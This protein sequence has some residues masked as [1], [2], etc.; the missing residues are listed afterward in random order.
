MRHEVHKHRVRVQAHLILEH[1]A[2]L[3]TESLL[4]VGDN[5]FVHGGLTAK[6]LDGDGTG[7][8]KT[9]GDGDAA[10]VSGAEAAMEDINA[11]VSAW[12]L[13]GNT[14][15][16]RIIWGE[17]SPVWL[18]TFSSPDSRDMTAAPRTELEKVTFGYESG[19]VNTL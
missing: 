3:S 11:K 18:R 6:H 12:M 2:C 14:S 17:D 7:V 4:Q 15:V 5:L 8:E 10:A 1:I 16:P 19:S 9:E 13:E